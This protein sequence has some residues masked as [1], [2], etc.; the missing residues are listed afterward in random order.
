M[1]LELF[2][3]KAILQGSVVGTESFDRFGT[4]LNSIGKT[5]DNVNKQ[6]SGLQSTIKGLAGA[7][8]AVQLSNM[9]AEFAR[10]TIQLDAFQ[11]QLSIGFGAASQLEL[12]QLRNTLRELGISQDEALGSAVRFTSS[13]KLSGQS[14]AEANKT[15]EAASKLILS[16][17]LS[18]DGAN[19]VYYA[20]S[21]TASKGKLMME[22]LGG[23]LGDQLAG[24]MQQ[25]ADAM[26]ISTAELIKNMQAGKVSATDFFKALQKIGDNIDPSKL[27]SAAQS[28]G[29][30]KNS[31]FDFK[32]SILNSKDIKDALDAATSAIKAMAEN[33]ETLTT[34]FVVGVSVAIGK[35]T[36]AFIANTMASLANA[37]ANRVVLASALA[38]AQA[39]YAE[40]ASAQA[41]AAAMFIEVEAI[42]GV[43]TAERVM[44]AQMAAT[45]AATQVATA[46]LAV[47]SAAARAAGV[48]MAAFGRAGMGVVSFL[49]G[50][51]GIALAAISVGLYLFASRTSDAENASNSFANAQSDLG[52]VID[53]TTGKINSQNESLIRQA[54]LSAAKA[55]KEN[56][57]AFN[58]SANTVSNSIMM[59][60]N[61]LNP[62]SEGRDRML[63]QNYKAINDIVAKFNDSVRAGAPKT[64]EFER[65]LTSLAAK[66]PEVKKALGDIN[67]MMLELETTSINRNK[68]ILAQRLLTGQATEADKA[69]A[70]SYGLLFEEQ[71]KVNAADEDAADA[72]KKKIQGVLESLI[73][74]RQVISL[75]EKEGFVL[76]KLNSAG[77]VSFDANNKMVVAQGANTQAIRRQAA[78]LYSETEAQKAANKAKEDAKALAKN[79]QE[80]VDSLTS[81]GAQI[82]FQID[83]FQQYGEKVA[84]AQEALVL[85]ET[86]QGKYKDASS[87]I[88]ATMLAE[89]KA[90]DELAA[91]YDALVAAK[92][93]DGAVQGFKENAANKITDL[94][95][96]AIGIMGGDKYATM[97]SDFSQELDKQI[98]RFQ[99]EQRAAGVSEVEISRRVVEMNQAKTEAMAEYNEQIQVIQQLEGDFMVGAKAGLQDYS[100]QVQDVASAMRKAF[101]NAFQATEDALVNFVMTGKLSF[102]DLA[103]SIIA[104]LVRIAIQQAIMAPLVAWFKGLGMFAA[105][106][107][108]FNTG[109]TVTAYAA[110]GVVTRPTMFQHAGGLGVMGEAGP[111]AVM[112]LRRMGNGRLGVEA[113]GSGGTQNVTVNVNVESGTS[114]TSG[115][116]GKAAE[117]GKM[118]AMVVR[119]ELIQQKR[120]GGLLASGG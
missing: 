79:A 22:E 48:G 12:N 26:G 74:Q 99:R 38:A 27:E 9:I 103:S 112:P 109:G 19:R 116:A 80:N 2:N 93:L 15:F 57:A 29:K 82:Q 92:R 64:A 100:N 96:R 49:G 17:K 115:D 98:D 78:A 58:S 119:T 91:K 77:L 31:W 35:A 30:L 34:I 51:F 85:F 28:L 44:A 24:F 70:R 33:A 55:A 60:A 120:P 62:A 106:G 8:G 56:V 23:Q 97:R 11:K 45:A 47:H 3:V 16:N 67:E 1:A 87:A 105:N 13:L 108:A 25:T 114:S 83:H 40:A 52:K 39:K 59:R 7:L 50:P 102:K 42:A 69:L 36:S 81:K 46:E 41:A 37:A 88:K 73:L 6:M 68:S 89:A 107:A 113:G 63:T 43:V 18:A 14:A 21:Q 95:Q 110:G 53:L 66:S 104:D 101:V 118:V 76:E 32:V 111:E 20:M 90:V 54:R 10:A 5:A 65:A 75:S 94:K 84:S 61:S 72:L 117:L 4:K 71:S 86:T